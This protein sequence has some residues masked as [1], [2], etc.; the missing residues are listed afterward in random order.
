MSSVDRPERLYPPAMNP[1]PPATETEMARFA[2]AMFS[3]GALASG[4]LEGE[5]HG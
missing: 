1:I 5:I 2:V 4:G 3:I